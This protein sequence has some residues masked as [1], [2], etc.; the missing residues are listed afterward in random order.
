MISFDNGY[1]YV[2]SFIHRQISMLT[3]FG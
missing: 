3:L 1:I 2:S